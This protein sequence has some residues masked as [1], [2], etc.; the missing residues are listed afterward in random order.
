MKKCERCLQAKNF[1]CQETEGKKGKEFC[2]GTTGEVGGGS[3]QPISKCR[4][5]REEVDYR[6]RNL[7]QTH[8]KVE[9]RKIVYLE[10]E[11]PDFFTP[12][13]ITE[14]INKSR[15]LIE[16]ITGILDGQLEARTDSDEE[17]NYFKKTLFR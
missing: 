15:K 2:N 1:Y 16:L 13:E 12:E 5:L 8:I 4:K 3:N 14:R 11:K 9:E 6:L 7:L 17:K 10:E